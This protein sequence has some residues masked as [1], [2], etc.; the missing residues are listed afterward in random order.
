MLGWRTV[1]FGCITHFR[2]YYNFRIN[3][4][5]IKCCLFGVVYLHLHQKSLKKSLTNSYTTTSEM[6]CRIVCLLL[7]KYTGVTMFWQKLIKDRKQALD[8]DMYVGLLLFDLNKAFAF[9]WLP[10]RLLLWKMYA[11]GISR[12]SCSVLLSYSSNILQKVKIAPIEI[13]CVQ[14]TM[15]APQGSVKVWCYF[16]IFVNDSSISS[17]LFIWTSLLD[18]LWPDK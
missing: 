15:G 7:Q 16:G 8:K 3:N 18:H 13:E 2:F 17:T 6:W 12:D 1:S 9:D 11:Y 10:H 14:M 4:V 5:I